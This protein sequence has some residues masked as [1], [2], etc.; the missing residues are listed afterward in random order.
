MK[1]DKN[2]LLQTSLLQKLDYCRQVSL[3]FKEK[4]KVHSWKM[5]HYANA[6]QRQIAVP[7]LI[8]GK[9]DLDINDSFEI[10]G[11]VIIIQSSIHEEVIAISNMYA[12][13]QLCIYFVY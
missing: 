8:S 12:C 11:H 2:L 1:K 9:V 7:I 13:T 4:L 6:N 10:E 3:K 5:I